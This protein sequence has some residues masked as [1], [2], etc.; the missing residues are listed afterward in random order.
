MEEG[1]VFFMHVYLC[2]I[3]KFDLIYEHCKCDKWQTV[4]EGTTDCSFQVHTTLIEIYKFILFSM[5]L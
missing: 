3:V 4:H 1:S 2:I 5:T